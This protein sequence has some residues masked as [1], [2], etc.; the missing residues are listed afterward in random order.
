MHV[1]KVGHHDN[2]LA[3]ICEYAQLLTAWT[4]LFERTWNIIRRSA[5]PVRTSYRVNDRSE[6]VD[7]STEVS[8]WLNF[9]AVTVSVDVGKVR[10]ITG[11]V[12]NEVQSTR[13]YDE[14]QQ[15]ILCLIPQLYGV[16]S[17]GK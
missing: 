5:F 10:F 9:R 13:T 16:R 17:S 12:L 7:A 11:D 6:P 2:A 15:E 14:M 4:W 8:D 1:G 3:R